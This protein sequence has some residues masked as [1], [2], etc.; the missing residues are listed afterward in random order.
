MT[1]KVDLKKYFKKEK[2]QKL[3]NEHIKNF[4]KAKTNTFKEKIYRIGDEIF[5]DNNSLIHGSRISI[6]K[7]NV[8]KNY[9]LIAPE[10]Y[11]ETNLPKKKPYVVEFWEINENISLKN[12]I[13][14][15]CGVTLEIYSKEGIVIE[16]IISS[17]EDIENHISKVS[18]YET[19]RDYIIYP[20]QEQRYLPNKINNNSTM[21]FIVKKDSKEKEKILKNDIFSDS[22]DFEILEEILPNW[23]IEKYVKTGFTDKAETGREKA[24]IYGIPSSFIEGILVNSQIENDELSLNKIK[25]IFPDCYICNIYG[26]IIR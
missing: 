11:T 13:N 26:K 6:D 8:I 15:Y 23:Y 1:K 19:F 21:A 25:E 9:G 22:F 3:F 24:I 17:F 12:Y 20:N 2:T 10:F 5:L 4:E 16:K 18:K 14:K 7:L